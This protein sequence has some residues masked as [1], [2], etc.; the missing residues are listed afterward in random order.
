V[1]LPLSTRRSFMDHFFDGQQ[2]SGVFVPGHTSRAVGSEVDLE[3]A[4]ADE[5]MVF[6]SRGVVRSKR[7][8]GRRDL[9]A[10][11]NIE[12]LA[13]EQNTRDVIL[14][15]AKGTP[16]PLVRRASRRL[17]IVLPVDLACEAG[18]S[19]A[20]TED[21]SRDGAFIATEVRPKLGSLVEL[22]LR[23]PG[24]KAIRVRAEVRW[25]RG[26]GRPGMG[27]RFVFASDETQRLIAAFLDQVKQQLAG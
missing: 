2:G 4:F 1:L 27:V 9:P 16:S 10:G 14:A 15:F 22:R 21:I 18:K 7:L 3:I 25:L 24:V 19:S 23:P 20:S 17:P 13:S 8:V 6:H 11:V 12:F 26:Q 5:Q